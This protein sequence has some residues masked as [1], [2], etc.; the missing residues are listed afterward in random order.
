[1]ALVL[2]LA[3][4]ALSQ[5]LERPASTNGPFPIKGTIDIKFNTHLGA[6]PAK[7]VQD[8][9][10]LSINV[11]NSAM[12]HGTIA[13][14]PQI[15]DGWISKSIIQ[16][17]N[18][19]YNIDCDVVNPRNTAQ[20]RNVGRMYGSVPIDPDGIYHYDTGTLVVDVLPMGN[21]GGFSSKFGGTAA[22]KPLS[23][24]VGWL[25]SLKCEAVNITRSV[26]GKPM[27]VTLKKYDKME[28]RQTVISAGP[29]QAYQPVTANGEMLYDYDK[30]CWFFNNVT[31]QYDVGGNI[32]QDRLTGTIRW[33]ESP[34]R[35]SN[36]EGEYDFDVRVNEPVPGDNAVF[37]ST[38]TTDESAFFE[39]DNT[40]PAVN[41]TMKYKDSQPVDNT[42]H[43]AVTVDLTGNNITKQQT[44]VIAKLI[45]FATVIPM[46]SD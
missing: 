18:L 4:Q 29:V 19:Q 27:T 13:D 8:I 12:F 16:N 7:G 44:M 45:L 33:I 2:G 25:D 40:I 20:T 46:N 38:A 42:P 14:T 26:N 35:K 31:I 3:F 30:S 22:G 34:Q 11:A 23:R 43:S 17:R 28:F 24:P 10:N 5:S 1:M 41:G 32:K 9:Y 37:A 39:T 36:G 6:K 15:I 21:A